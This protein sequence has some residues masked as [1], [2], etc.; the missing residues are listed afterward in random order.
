MTKR[1]R[2][3]DGLQYGFVVE[4]ENLEDRDYYTS[5]DKAHEAFKAA[6]LHLLEKAVV[7]DYSF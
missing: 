5:E 6:W 3:Q 4:F 7:L 2:G 1:G